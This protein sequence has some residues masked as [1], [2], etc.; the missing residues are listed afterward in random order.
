M[1]A[2]LIVLAGVCASTTASLAMWI[3]VH[4][5]ESAWCEVVNK[6][7]VRTNATELQVNQAVSAA[8]RRHQPAGSVTEA[9]LTAIDYAEHADIWFTRPDVFG[10]SRE[11]ASRFIREQLD[12]EGHPLRVEVLRGDDMPTLVFIEHDEVDS[13]VARQVAEALATL[14][15]RPM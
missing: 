10:A 11:R 8:M 2:V 14:G 12:Q 15:V 4:A 6:R 9:S 5:E 1:R 3:A 7:L 13:P